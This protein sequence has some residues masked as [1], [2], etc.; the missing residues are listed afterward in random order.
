MN[1][2]TSD[3]LHALTKVMLSMKYSMG[4]INEVRTLLKKDTIVTQFL[5]ELV[6]A[7]ADDTAAFN[8]VINSYKKA[9]IN[10][11][12]AFHEETISEDSEKKLEAD[13]QSLKRIGWKLDKVIKFIIVKKDYDVTLT[14]DLITKLYKGP[15]KAKAV[16]VKE[17]KPVK[18]P[19]DPPKN[20][21]NDFAHAQKFLNQAIDSDESPDMT[22]SEAY[23]VLIT[24]GYTDEVA[25]KLVKHLGWDDSQFMR[26]YNQH[27][28]IPLAKK[29]A[30]KSYVKE[31]TQF[32]RIT[33]KLKQK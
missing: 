1:E 27:K 4:D 22:G 9:G 23:T 18:W 3:Q 28:G 5:L 25:L 21:V 11:S 14:S 24:A 20:K 29:T 6:Y 13:I 12:S 30:K 10:P 26:T 32:A 15:E 19:N 7:I 33:E 8:A 17:P 2:A 16:K 31:G